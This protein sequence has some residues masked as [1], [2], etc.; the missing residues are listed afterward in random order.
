M[1]S[2]LNV[3]TDALHHRAGQRETG[4]R[5]KVA[6]LILAGATLAGGLWAQETPRSQVNNP[7]APSVTA[8][9]SAAQPVATE[10][11]LSTTVHEAWVA[12]GRNE[13]K[14]FDMVKQCALISAQKRGLTLPNTEAAGKAM[15]MAIKASARRDPNQLLYAVVD[16]A[17][18][19]TA[20]G[21]GTANAP[22]TDSK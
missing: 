21:A 14:F 7:G 13:D 22:S 1:H 18:R 2:S 15:G 10:Q 6:V 3:N 5:E 12:S 8:D 20:M 19:K 9:N 16:A 17:V 4:M 11:L